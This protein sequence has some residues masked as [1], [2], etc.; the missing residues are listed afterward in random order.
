MNTLLLVLLTV[1]ATQAAAPAAAP[2][3]ASTTARKPRPAPTP[4]RVLEGTV[5]TPEG[6]PVA[7]ALVLAQPTSIGSFEQPLTARTDA[8]GAFRLTLASSRVHRMRVEAA[9][10]AAASVKD[11]RPGTPVAVTLQKGAAI[12]GLVRDGTSGAPV[13]GAVVEARETAFS[14]RAMWEPDVGV[15]RTTTDDRGR[16]RVDGLSRGLH[17][18]SAR[19]RGFGQGGRSDVPVGGRVDIY[20]F[21]GATVTGT[22]RDAEGRPVSRAAIR[23]ESE[24]MRGFGAGSGGGGTVASEADGRFEMTGLSPGTYRA[25]ARHADF[26][27]AW[28]PGITVERGEETDVEV[29]L[30]RGV[31]VSGRLMA[32][33]DKPVAGRVGV[34][35]TDDRPVPM[36]LEDRLRS[37]AGADGRFLLTLPAGSHAL[38]VVAAGYTPKRVEVEAVGE[39]VDLGDVLLEPGLVIRGR[40][41][42]RAGLPVADAQ[43]FGRQARMMGGG[44][45]GRADATT[46]ADG[47]FVLG[48]LVAGNYALNVIARGFAGQSR[49]V[50]AGGT[51]DFTLDPAGSIT[52]QVVDEAGTAVEAFQVVAR[53]LRE[54]GPSAPS[55]QM[56]QFTAADGRFVLNDVAEG[57]WVVEASA[58][59]RASGVVSDV[60]V[61]AGAGTDVGRIRLSAGGIV[62]GTVLDATGA[63]VPGANVTV[64]GAGQDWYGRGRQATTDPAG[65]FELRG[66]A[67]GPVDV[68]AQHP[69]YAPGRAAGLE[70]DPTRGPTEARIVMTQ[71]GR[72][73]GRVLRRDGS[74][75]SAMVHAGPQ[76]RAV[77]MSG[78][79]ANTAADGSFTIEHVPAGRTFLAVMFGSGG[80]MESTQTREVDV[81]E[82]ETTTA[83]FVSREILVTGHVTRGGAPAPGIRLR[84]GSMQGGRM[85]MSAGGF[86]MLSAPP[87]GPQR[88]TAVTD[89]G[90]AFA[91]IVDQPGRHF[92]NASTAD[93]RASFPNREI[94]IPDADSHVLELAIGGAP[95]AGIVLDRD[96]EQPLA[97]ANLY[98]QPSGGKPGGGA[99]GTTT[100]DG[101]FTFEL[102]PGPYQLRVGAAGYAGETMDVE[103]AAGGTSD[104]RVLLGRGGTITGRVVDAAG[105]GMSGVWINATEAGGGFGVMGAMGQGHSLPD[106]SFRIDGLAE[107]TYTLGATSQLGM[108]ATRRGVASGQTG[109]TLTL[110]PGGRVNL[111]V[112]GPD[113]APAEGARIRVS[114]TEGA[115]I[116]LQGSASTSAQGMAQVLAPAGEVEVEV[117][118]EKLRAK[119][120][121]TVTPGDTAAAELVLAEAPPEQPR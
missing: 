17:S 44:W 34:Q 28:L 47:S 111:M 67:A 52:G 10:W 38:A 104:L 58:P 37:E 5:R 94:D 116:W 2:P 91:L 65:T 53:P 24:A 11:V 120:A 59:E 108:F 73:E 78:L 87:A 32:G 82:G 100:A 103:V 23:L 79:S 55:P 106:G 95:L 8:A 102:D 89:E 93:G 117:S 30:T 7:N 75:M 48:G 80:V 1:A 70:V 101:R 36:G 19:L 56:D 109:V 40:V 72:I 63:P 41:R 112:R 66:V 60:R 84:L 114:K 97:N 46:E 54:M 39:A 88:F 15:V 35:E 83:E 81:R 96:T 121:L 61:A 6:Q 51:A 14:V 20:L 3:P 9:G 69:S 33:E 62:R 64:Q 27:P 86:S 99:G 118:K 71:G 92:V 49:Q 50:E 68:T 31:K 76:A 16:F 57:T 4:S 12:E 42:D 98:A 85:M 119:A 29:T 13:P 105:R 25:V 110:Q 21:P 90:G 115:P 45:A 22:V 113:G 18:V 107:G 77:P 43:V 74:G 26:S